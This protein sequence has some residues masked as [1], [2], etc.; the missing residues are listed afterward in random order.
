[1]YFRKISDN[2]KCI[3]ELQHFFRKR[4]FKIEKPL[5]DRIFSQLLGLNQKNVVKVILTKLLG[6][7][8]FTEFTIN[9][10]ENSQYSYMLNTRIDRFEDLIDKSIETVSIARHHHSLPFQEIAYKICKHYKCDLLINGEFDK[11]TPGMT[12]RKSDGSI[13]LIVNSLS[14][15]LKDRLV[16]YHELAHAVLH[17]QP[18]QTGLIKNEIQE[19]NEHEAWLFSINCVAHDNFST[20]EQ[21][22]KNNDVSQLILGF[23]FPMQY[24]KAFQVVAQYFADNWIS[25]SDEGTALINA[26]PLI[27]R[28]NDVI[29]EKIAMNPQLLY[30]L[31]G[32]M[33]EE[34]MAELFK[35]MGYLVEQTAKTRDGGVDIL[36]IKKIDDI[37]LR[38]LIECKKYAKKRKV[39]VSLVRSLFGV[40]HH[41]GASKAIIATTSEFTKPAADFAEAHKWDLELKDFNGIIH[42]TN[43]YINKK[44]S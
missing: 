22:S 35:G 41:M 37:S 15:Q 20:K 28:V 29:I 36:A 27:V 40:K 10:M 42:W 4:F 13:S 32:F 25:V 12:I 38:F 1:L 8:C 14:S 39:G 17:V 44:N 9:A 3:K 6:K 24:D 18:I 19:L 2:Y 43:H 23:A 33:F 26:K 21:I 34:F 11:T 7:Q 16:F 31:N 30:Q 5:L